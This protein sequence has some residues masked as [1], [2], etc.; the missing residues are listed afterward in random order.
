MNQGLIWPVLFE[1]ARADGMSTGFTPN[2]IKVVVKPERGL[3]GKVR[4]VRLTALL[5]DG[6]MTGELI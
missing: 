5:E 3:T 2:Y 4:Q 6:E 1:Q